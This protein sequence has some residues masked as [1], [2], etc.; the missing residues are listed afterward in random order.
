M[1]TNLIQSMKARSPLGRVFLALF[2]TFNA[3]MAWASYEAVQ[4]FRNITEAGSKTV[5][6]G[7]DLGGL[8]SVA[9][10]LAVW[11]VGGLL[12]GLLV[13]VTRAQALH[14]KERHGGQE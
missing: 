8:E 5:V 6:L 10:V 3:F 14:D 7:L 2:L 13:H 4:A 11:L 12:T 9:A 1:K